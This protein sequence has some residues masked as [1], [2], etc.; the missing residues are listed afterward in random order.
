MCCVVQHYLLLEEEEKKRKNNINLT[1][2]HY[3]V[4]LRVLGESETKN[5]KSLFGDTIYAFF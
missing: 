4:L 5:N 3:M 1:H 2:N